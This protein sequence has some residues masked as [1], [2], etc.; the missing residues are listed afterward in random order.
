MEKAQKN[1]KIVAN[2]K[3]DLDKKKSKVEKSILKSTCQKAAKNLKD[4]LNRPS[5]SNSGDVM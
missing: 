1:N 5:T 3:Q 2:K 4:F